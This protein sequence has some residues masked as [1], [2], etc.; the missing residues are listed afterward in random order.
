MWAP[1]QCLVPSLA[2]FAR[3]NQ[4]SHAFNSTY[5]LHS[6]ISALNNKA[7]LSKQN[8]LFSSPKPTTPLNFEQSQTHHN[9]FPTLKAPAPALDTSAASSL[10][11]LHR[12]SLLYQLRHS[13]SPIGYLSRPTFF[14]FTGTEDPSPHICEQGGSNKK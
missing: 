12:A 10:Y 11:Q 3:L 5:P 7:H 9:L 4:W 1:R 14:S 2:Q 6:L 13:H 8:N